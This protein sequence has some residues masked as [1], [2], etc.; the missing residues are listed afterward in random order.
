M[1]IFLGIQVEQLQG[2]IRLHLDNYVQETL[3]EYK[4]LQ[5]KLLYLKLAL[6]QPWLV[7]TKEDCPILPNPRKQKFCLIAKLLFAATWV[8]F[9]LLLAAAQL[10][11]F[12]A[13]AGKSNWAA[14]GVNGGLQS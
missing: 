6:I 14:D 8:L 3:D 5:A 10:S 1:D 2:N 12:C 11:C 4:L 9:Y 7:L 13:S